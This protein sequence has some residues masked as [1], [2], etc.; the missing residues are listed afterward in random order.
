MDS[1]YLLIFSVSCMVF[2][3]ALYRFKSYQNAY[4]SLFI[5]VMTVGSVFLDG[6][7]I[8]CQYF[9]GDGVN[10]SVLY[11]LTTTMEG[12]EISD[13]I[14][15]SLF[16]LVLCAVIIVIIHRILFR[17]Q[18]DGKQS[19]IFTLFSV[20]C[21]ALALFI[22]PA[23]SQLSG[24]TLMTTKIDGSDFNQYYFNQPGIIENPKYN[25][26]YIYGESLERTYFDQKVFPNLLPDL[27]KFRASSLDFSNT[28]Q[29]PA[30]EFTIAG[31]VASQCGLPLFKP[32]AFNGQNTVTSFYPESKCLGDILSE[33]GYET[34]FYQGANLHFADKDAF[35]KV[36]GIKHA[37]GLTESGLKDNFDVQNNWG[38]YDSVVM[39]KAWEKFSELSSSGQRFALFA[40]TVDTHPPR[41]Y[42]SPGCRQNSYSIEGHKVD[43]LSAVLC[44]QE[45]I[46][47]FVQ[48]IQSSPWA[49]NTIVVL[50]SDHL[51]MPSTAVSVDY[52]NKLERRDLF[53]VLGPKI[54][55]EIKSQPRSTLDNG[56]T[57]LDL[58]GGGTKI[59]LGRSSASE[60]S[61]TETIPEFK[62]KLY[63]WGD[64]IRG[65]WGIPDRIDRFTL[66]TRKN[67]ISFSGHTYSLPILIDIKPNE[68]LPVIDDSSRTLSLRQSLAFLPEGERFLWVDKCFRPA[69]L[70][71]NDLSL[72]E[73]WCVTQ[74]KAGG[75]VTVEEVMDEQYEGNVSIDD[76]PT[77]SAT[78]QREQGLLK[79]NPDEI[80]YVS[81]TFKFNL[82]GLPLFIENVMGLGRQEPWGRWSDALT[83]PSILL[84][85]KAPFVPEFDVEIEAKAYGKNIDT[86]VAVKIGEQTQYVRFGEK[87]TRVTLRFKGD[88]Y[89]RLIMITPPEPTL[90]REGS[91]LGQM[92]TSPARKIGIGLIE[93]KVVPVIQTNKK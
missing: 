83:S 27:D 66:D 30:T 24:N 18:S 48:R 59:G 79:M 31:I 26:V 61:L 41:G 34:Y 8:V 76:G 50:S 69:T 63:A 62:N 16:A 4:L 14:W 91:V 19:W 87:P 3:T 29:M 93:V 64:S 72:S 2:A 90:S 9:T 67:E 86:P 6:F 58:L 11:T 1:L 73:K 54:K 20:C 46:A 84:L 77:N 51:A 53:F 49:S 78:Y 42:I 35:F 56:A 17:G 28:L 80:R 37:W 32:T 88:S 92:Y 13:Y 65:L 25:L 89:S 15:P 22:S 38:L 52:L 70:W 33:S 75:K 47:R 82:D 23:F 36:H 60:K 39:D 43:A 45:N 5:F 44:S 71:R 7:W 55:A 85:Y 81:D 57:V 40:L 21:S 10:E 68:V 74:G 12:G